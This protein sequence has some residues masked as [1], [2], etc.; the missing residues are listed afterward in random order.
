[1]QVIRESTESE[2]VAAF[3]QAEID[4]P[5]WAARIYEQLPNCDLSEEMI[6][7]PN[8]DNPVENY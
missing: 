7:S 3:L 2:M 5:R 8:W 4:S 6:R 1:M